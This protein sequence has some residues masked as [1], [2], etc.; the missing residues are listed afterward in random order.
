MEGERIHVKRKKTHLIAIAIAAL[1]IILFGFYENS[2]KT[3]NDILNNADPGEIARVSVVVSSAS[4]FSS[5]DTYFTS[6]QAAIRA[7]AKSV[8]ALP[9]KYYEHT[10]AAAIPDH[11]KEY[12]SAVLLENRLVAF[13]II[14]SGDLYYNNKKYRITSSADVNEI[15]SPI[16]Q[17]EQKN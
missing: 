14:S 8:G 3:V 12:D 11:G 16:Y 9:V 17:W 7:F 6:D 15:L 13:S 4:T 10:S 1:A 5:F 2:Y